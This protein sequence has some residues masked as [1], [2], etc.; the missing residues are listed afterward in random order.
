MIRDANT[1]KRFEE[2]LIRKEPQGSF[3]E[4]LKLYEGMWKEAVTLGVLP[5]SD[6]LD[7]IEADFELARVLNCLKNSSPE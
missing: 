3:Q 1:L 7:G 4:T 5:L 6:P 2:D